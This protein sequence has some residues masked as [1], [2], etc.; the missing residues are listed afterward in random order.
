MRRLVRNGWPGAREI[1]AGVQ[2]ELRAA[3][4]EAEALRPE[5][6]F[7]GASGSWVRARDALGGEVWLLRTPER[8]GY[9]RTP[10]APAYFYEVYPGALVVRLPAGSDPL[11]DAGRWTEAELVSPGRIARWS[12]ARSRPMRARWR[13]AYPLGTVRRRI[14][15]SSP[16]RCRRT[17][18]CSRPTAICWRCSPV[19]A[20]LHPAASG[21]QGELAERFYRDAARVLPDAAHL[22]LIGQHLVVY[23]YDSP[24]TRH[25]DLLGTR[26]LAG[27]IHQTARQTLDT[28]VGGRYRGDCDDLSELYLEIARR[29]GRNAQMIGLPAHAALAWAEP[30]GAGGWRTYVLH[31]GQPRM[32]AAPSLG[33][34]LEQ[35]YRSFGAS[36]VLD[37]TKL[38]VLLRFSGENTRQSWYLSQRIFSDPEYA[39][40]MIDVQRDWHFQTYQR[41]IEKMRA[42]IDAGDVDPANFSELSGLYHYTGRYAEAAE[43]LERASEGAESEQTRVSLETDRM[44]NLF[45]AGRSS[46]RARSR[47]TCA[48]GRSPRSSARWAR[49]WSIR[50]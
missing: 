5:Q 24:D 8:S 17:S 38:E 16:M 44:L 29:Q 18:S 2:A 48:S 27:D 30:D 37:F 21:E 34:S 3:V 32:F 40:A 13:A 50:A 20:T 47:S 45:R 25:P 49:R 19:T 6:R 35:A 4:L 9:A 39:R 33:E 14:R 23:T 10:A 1:P 28:Q 15:A 46:R 26:Q 31:T 22:D 43:A 41:A 36:E 42:M 7:A 11:S 12:A